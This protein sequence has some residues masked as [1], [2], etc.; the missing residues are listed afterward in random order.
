MIDPLNDRLF[1]LGQSNNTNRDIHKV[2]EHPIHHPLLNSN[3][4]SADG[5]YGNYCCCCGT[6]CRRSWD[7]VLNRHSL[8]SSSC[9]DLDNDKR[10]SY[11]NSHKR[12]YDSDG[13]FEQNDTVADYLVTRTVFN[14]PQTLL[15]LL[16]ST[17][18]SCL[19]RH[20]RVYS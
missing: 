9:H 20:N 12:C 16:S 2:F 8:Q 1:S 14:C 6:W 4:E 15:I 17:R 10:Y 18:H 11:F 3:M 7:V 13:D 19:Q 5:Y